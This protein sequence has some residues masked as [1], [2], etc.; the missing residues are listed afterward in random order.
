MSPLHHGGW[1]SLSPP[2]QFILLGSDFIRWNWCT[3]LQSEQYVENFNNPD[4]PATGAKG[5]RKA[6]KEGK[7]GRKG[8]REGG[9]AAK[10]G[11]WEEAKTEVHNRNEVKIRKYQH[12]IHK[13]KEAMSPLHHGGWRSLSPPHQYILLGSDFIRWNW[14]KCLQ[15]EQ[16][17]ETPWYALG[18]TPSN[19]TCPPCHRSLSSMKDT[20]GCWGYGPEDG[21]NGC[22]LCRLAYSY[23]HHC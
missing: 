1:R 23:A 19:N 5:G 16:Y 13:L 22:P 2:H 6:G 17:V 7:W 9:E 11:R 18:E 4:I 21:M 20:C 15:S 3:F 12:K 8:G 10:E 14:C